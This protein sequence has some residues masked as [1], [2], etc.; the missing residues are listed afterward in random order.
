[1]AKSYQS[2][3]NKSILNFVIKKKDYP[4]KARNPIPKQNCVPESKAL[5]FVYSVVSALTKK[6][7]AKSGNN[8]F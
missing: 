5:F 1:M 2:G 7:P 4:N 6:I 8:I 3:R